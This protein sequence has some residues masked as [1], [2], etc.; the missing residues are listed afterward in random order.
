MYS[1]EPLVA[2]GS[3]YYNYAAGAMARASLLCLQCIGLFTYLPGYRLARRSYDSFLL[4]VILGGELE[5]ESD[6]KP[7]RAVRG[8]AVLLD[9]YR[10]HCYTS[11]TG[12]QALWLHFDGPGARGYYDWITRSGGPVLSSGNFEELH[13]RLAGLFREFDTGC[14]P[15]EGQITREITEAL[16]LLLAPSETSPGRGALDG[17]LYTINENL[18]REL[19]VRQLAEQAHFSEYHFIR[20][21]R[22]QVG[23]T[24]RQ[25]IITA[26]MERARHLLKTTDL[27]LET[28]SEQVGYASDNVFCTQFKHRYGVTP[29]EYRQS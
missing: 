29:T 19:S 24:P 27:P 3:C 13:S 20:L 1:C 12:W 15:S 2:P 6:G 17:V 7:F 25:Y 16:G 21:F 18:H 14:I 8:N 23:M 9:C 11:A 26:R 5:G 4:E 10:P 22:S 28:I